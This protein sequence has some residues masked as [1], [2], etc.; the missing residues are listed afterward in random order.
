MTWILVGHVTMLWRLCPR[1]AFTP[2]VVF[3][4]VIQREPLFTAEL[5]QVTSCPTTQLLDCS[6]G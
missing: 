2:H 5:P 4:L 3:L 6:T 1:V